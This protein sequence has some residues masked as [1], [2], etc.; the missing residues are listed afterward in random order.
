MFCDVHLSTVILFA[1]HHWVKY[2]HNFTFGIIRATSTFLQCLL[3]RRIHIAYRTWFTNLSGDFF[4]LAFS[5]KLFL[6]S[7]LSMCFFPLAWSVK[8]DCPEVESSNTLWQMFHRNLCF[9]FLTLLNQG[10][11]CG[12]SS[13]SS[14]NTFWWPLVTFSLLISCKE[15]RFI[16]E[17][18]QTH[19]FSP[20]HIKSEDFKI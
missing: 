6:F 19:G 8:A 14:W 5:K 15:N 20:L 11:N 18:R 9:S 4:T 3:S 16:K 7:K 17:R 2:P 10:L 13:Q 12:L 1:T